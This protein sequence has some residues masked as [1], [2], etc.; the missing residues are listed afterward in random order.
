[1]TAPNRNKQT[2]TG[3]RSCTGAPANTVSLPHHLK[4]MCAVF[5]VCPGTGVHNKVS[6]I[7]LTVVQAT[8]TWCSGCRSSIGQAGANQSARMRAGKTGMDTNTVWPLNLG[9]VTTTWRLQLHISA[10]DP[11]GNSGK[12]STYPPLTF[13]VNTAPHGVQLKIIDSETSS[14]L[15]RLQGDTER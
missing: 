3:C 5:G 11:K 14:T 7:T 12:P 6:V 1:M 13:A 4:M 15:T 10:E 9:N 2:G 8:Y